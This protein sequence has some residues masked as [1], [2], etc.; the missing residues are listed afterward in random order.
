M[1]VRGKL[2]ELPAETLDLHREEAI[3]PQREVGQRG[4]QHEVDAVGDGVDPFVLREGGGVGEVGAL[5]VG[6]VELARAAEQPFARHLGHGF[7]EVLGVD[8][9]VFE[10]AGE[11]AESLEPAVDLR[12]VAIVGV[13]GDPLGVEDDAG[14]PL[15]VAVEAER[16]GDAVEDVVVVFELGD[17]FEHR[18]GGAQHADAEVEVTG[19]VRVVCHGGY[20]VEEEFHDGLVVQPNGFE[21][22]GSRAVAGAEV[23]VRVPVRFDGVVGDDA[24]ITGAAAENGVEEVWVGFLR[25]FDDFALVVD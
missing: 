14:G 3:L 9:P 25:Y 10:E 22:V 21:A 20:L 6:V 7:D 18:E 5:D 24:K 23:V 4:V 8:A 17:K 2:G 15:G 13:H 1:A 12:G 11:V 19:H 16:V